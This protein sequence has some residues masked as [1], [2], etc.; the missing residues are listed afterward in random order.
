MVGSSD[1]DAVLMGAGRV[2]W[3]CSNVPLG[4]WGWCAGSTAVG[5]LLWVEDGQ[6]QSEV[7]QMGVSV[8]RFERLLRLLMAASIVLMRSFSGAESGSSN[9]V[10]RPW[11]VILPAVEK[12]R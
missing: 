2:F 4:R 3:A 12:S 10:R 7:S 5:L 11:R 9:E 6:R 1:R 8:G